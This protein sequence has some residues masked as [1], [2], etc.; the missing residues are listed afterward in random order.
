MSS[1]LSIS[2]QRGYFSKPLALYFTLI[3]PKITSRTLDILTCHTPMIVTVLIQCTQRSPVKHVGY[4]QLSC[5]CH[6]SDL[7]WCAVCCWCRQ[8]QGHEL[9]ATDVVLQA[10]S[11]SAV[12]FSTHV[13]SQGTAQEWRC[14]S[15]SRRAL[16]SRCF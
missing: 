3:S 11:L 16:Y 6:L 7:L 14:G 8:P 13:R 9:E 4:Q 2:V 12:H 5:T 10:S 1:T 15:L